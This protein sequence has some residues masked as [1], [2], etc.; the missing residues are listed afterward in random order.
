MFAHAIQRRL[1]AI[2]ALVVSREKAHWDRL[3]FGRLGGHVDRTVRAE[4]I[5][6]KATQLTIEGVCP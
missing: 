5:S 1:D 3:R 4:P 6:P 2:E